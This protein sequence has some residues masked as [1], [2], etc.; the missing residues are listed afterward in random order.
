MT[1]RPHAVG[2]G[3]ADAP[4]LVLGPSRTDTALFDRQVADLAGAHRVVRHDLRGH[5]GSQVV[6]GPCTI[7]DP[8]R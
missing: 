8:R 2:D 3:P 4:V 1:A 6:P 5:G 7:A